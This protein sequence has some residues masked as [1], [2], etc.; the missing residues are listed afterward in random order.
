MAFHYIGATGD[1]TKEFDLSIL[2]PIAAEGAES[3]EFTY[4]TIA[5][6]HCATYSYKGPWEGLGGMYDALFP[7]FYAQGHTYNQ[8]VREV[9]AVVDFEHTNNHVTEI[10]VGLG[11]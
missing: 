10:Q 9:Y 2:V 4:Q 3:A 5:P 7:A 11:I 1:M 8:Q 6:F